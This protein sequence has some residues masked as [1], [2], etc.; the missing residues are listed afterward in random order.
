MEFT[1][2]LEA[3]Q[4][5]EGDTASFKCSVTKPRQLAKWFKDDVEMMSATASSHQFS[6]SLTISNVKIE[7]SGRYKI[8]VADAECTAQLI[9]NGE[10]LITLFLKREHQSYSCRYTE[11]SEDCIIEIN[12]KNYH[13]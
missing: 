11:K 12:E 5:T 10:P 13:D 3:V 1:Q 6:H 2:T 4:V 8:K 7:D 9:V